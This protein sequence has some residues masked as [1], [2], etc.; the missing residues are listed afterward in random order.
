MVTI[1]PAYHVQSTA[2]A[3]RDGFP[4]FPHHESVVRLWTEKWRGPCSGGIYP[5][6]DGDLAD[7]EPIFTELGRASHNDTAILS[8]P[9]EYATPFLP[10]A[11]RLIDDAERA[12]SGGD[13]V[14]AKKL[15]LRA[16]AVYRIARFPINRSP[17]GQDA[18][19]SGK[20][21]YERGGALLNPPNVPVDIPFAHVD[22]AAGDR[23]API[24]AYL[25]VPMGDR[26][27]AGWPVVLFIC[28]LDAYRTD[29]TPPHP[30][31]RRSRVRHAELRDPRHR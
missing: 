9:D 28:G 13:T 25:R 27:E 10:A 26:P 31:P 7:F 19:A 16:A 1:S 15:F 5:F 14:R 11:Q 30:V 8:R 22:T 3:L 20:A 24:P 21:A 6:T 29:H 23:D 2:T 12:L 17:L 4:Y 18:W